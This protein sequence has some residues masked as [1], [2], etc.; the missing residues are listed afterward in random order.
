MMPMNANF[1]LQ[2]LAM[3]LPTLLASAVG[4]VMVSIF[5][6]RA[7]V[8]ANTAMWC[9]IVLLLNTI[10]GA[11]ITGMIPLIARNGGAQNFQMIYMAISLGRQL[12]SGAALVGLV[13]AVF[14]ERTTEADQLPELD[15]WSN[16]K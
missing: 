12:I 15:E 1:L 14:Q 7:R 5:R 8:A 9:L 4:L 16:R 13:Y 11:V 6:Q 10:L 3:T 2:N